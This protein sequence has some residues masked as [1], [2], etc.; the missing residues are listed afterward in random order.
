L[1]LPEIHALPFEQAADALARI[2]T[3]HT[4]GKLVLTV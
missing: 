4:R 1:R 3:K 2:G